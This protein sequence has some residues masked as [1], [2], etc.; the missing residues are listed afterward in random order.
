MGNHA[1]KLMIIQREDPANA[2]QWLNL[3]G[4]N[5][6]TLTINNA[7]GSEERVK[8]TDRAAAIETI[9]T[10]GA[11]SVEFSADGFFDDD[12]NGQFA[13]DQALAQSTPKLRAF[14]P[15]WGYIEAEQWFLPSSTFTGATTGQLANSNSFQASGAITFTAIA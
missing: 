4:V 14:V 8:C 3:C 9:R 7:V 5:S 15:G 1:G 6:T 13:A 2:G 10:Y 12:A 11:Q